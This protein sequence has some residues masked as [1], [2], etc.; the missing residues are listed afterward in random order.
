M[1]MPAMPA[2]LGTPGVSAPARSLPLGIGRGELVTLPA[3]M[4][5]A[6]TRRR[7]H[8]RGE[9]AEALVQAGRI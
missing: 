3:G 6:S 8:A 7:S 5:A 2:M 1:S 9:N 4:S